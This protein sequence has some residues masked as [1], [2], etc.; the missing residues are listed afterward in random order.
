M[1]VLNI[2]IEGLQTAVANSLS[3]VFRTMLSYDCES[4]RYENIRGSVAKGTWRRFCGGD[5]YWVGWLC[6][7]DQRI[8]LPLY[9]N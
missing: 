2:P 7:S 9:E 3:S 5:S 4:Q 6:R 8:G 1:S